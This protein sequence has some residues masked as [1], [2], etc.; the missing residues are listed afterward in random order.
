M[1]FQS[2]LHRYQSKLNAELDK[3]PLLVNFEQQTRIPKTYSTTTLA[4][5]YLLFTYLNLGGVGELL[6]NIASVILPA[7]WSIQA[8]DTPGTADDSQ[9]LT[10]WVVYAFFTIIEFWSAKLVQWI[11]AYWF[12]KT[13]LFVY[14]SFPSL[15]GARAIYHKVI[16]PLGERFLGLPP[17]PAAR[18]TEA[19][20]F[21][22]E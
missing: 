13:L 9:Y 18:A 15:G 11:P 8:L 3:S 10:Y 21:K 12:L 14:L 16:H 1:S 2:L 20:E 19:R 6:A 4:G 5:V 7:Y 22:S 17:M